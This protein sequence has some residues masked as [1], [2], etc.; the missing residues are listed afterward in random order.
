MIFSTLD[1]FCLLL[2]SIPSLLVVVDG[3]RQCKHCGLDNTHHPLKKCGQYLFSV[4]M[5]FISAVTLHT[6]RFLYLYGL[7]E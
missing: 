7:S 2:A 3:F 1:I 4:S 6:G 5:N